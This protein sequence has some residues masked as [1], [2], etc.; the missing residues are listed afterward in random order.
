MEQNFFGAECKSSVEFEEKTQ[1]EILD[2]FYKSKGWQI[3]RKERCK[4]YDLILKS[5][6]VDYK[7]EEKIR[8]YDYGDFTIELIQDSKTGNMGWYFKST[9]DYIYYVV[10]G[11]MYAVDF[12]ML[13]EFIT[14]NKKYNYALV[15]SIIGFGDSWNVGIRWVDLSNNI[16]TEHLLNS[17]TIEE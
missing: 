16:Y 13:K 9:A 8:K 3:S 17:R 6:G 7:I 10:P 11:K 15:R 2:P 4:E 12:E 14:K 1:K 5:N